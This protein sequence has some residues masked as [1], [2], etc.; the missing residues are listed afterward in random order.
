M[1][2]ISILTSDCIVYYTVLVHTSISENLNCCLC[3][4]GGD[5]NA[6]FRSRDHLHSVREGA[7]SIARA[8]LEIGPCRLADGARMH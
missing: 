6:V 3:S 1:T 4:P 8:F 5:P 7:R 2:V